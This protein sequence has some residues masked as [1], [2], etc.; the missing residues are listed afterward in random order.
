MKGGPMRC[1]NVILA[2]VLLTAMRAAAQF[3]VALPPQVNA[4]TVLADAY[5]PQLKLTLGNVIDALTP[6]TTNPDALKCVTRDS[7]Y[8]SLAALYKALGMDDLKAARVDSPGSTDESGIIRKLQGKTKQLYLYSCSDKTEVYLEDGQLRIS[9]PAGAIVSHRAD[10]SFNRRHW[11]HT[12]PKSY[13]RVASLYAAKGIGFFNNVS[14]GI[15]DD[16]A[17]LT[18]SIV[19]GVTSRFHFSASLMQSLSNAESPD[20]AIPDTVFQDRQNTVQRLIYNGGSAAVRLLVPFGAEGGRHVQRSGGLYVQ[21]GAVGDLTK[22]SDLR[23]TVGVVAEHMLALAVRNPASSEKVGEFLLGLRG[24]VHWVPE[25]TG[26][27]RGVADPEKVITF[28]QILV[29]LRQSE[30]LDYAVVYTFAQKQFNTYIPAIQFRV[31][32]TPKSS[33]SEGSKVAAETAEPATAANPPQPN[34]Q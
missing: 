4:D 25:H 22:Q 14:A 34:P 31:K 9:T 26:I 13:E 23:A 15:S 3:Q 28:G 20:A 21:L 10:G 17:F 24:G 18:T 7:A 29:G 11:V 16:D 5:K 1:L 30:S 32:A 19:S 6:D 12:F 33:S 8:T 27:L 2:L